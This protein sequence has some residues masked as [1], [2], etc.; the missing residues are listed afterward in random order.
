MI[1]LP[2]RPTDAN[3]GAKVE[4][5]DAAADLENASISNSFYD[6]LFPVVKVT[7]KVRF[8]RFVADV[9]FGTK[10]SDHMFSGLPHVV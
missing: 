2:R 6:E 5:V 1:D 9:F 10:H 8:T 3:A 4:H 7:P